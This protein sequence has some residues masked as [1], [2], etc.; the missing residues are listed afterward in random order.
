ME[1]NILEGCYGVDGDG[2][3]CNQEEDLLTTMLE[4]LIQKVVDVLTPSDSDAATKDMTSTTSER[5]DSANDT[6]TN[7]TEND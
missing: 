6:T 5:S 7:N 1:L 2:N 4:V 3:K